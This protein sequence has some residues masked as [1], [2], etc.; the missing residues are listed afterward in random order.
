[1]RGGRSRGARRGAGRSLSAV[2]AAFEASG[3]VYGYRRVRASIASGADGGEPMAVSEREV[4][5]AMREGAHGREAHAAARV[6]VLRGRDRR[7]P[8]ERPRWRADG[9]HDFSAPAPWLTVVT[10]VTEFRVRGG[11]AYLSPVIDCFDGE[12]AAWSVSRHPDSELTDSSLESY[13]ARRP[14]RPEPLVAHS[15]GGST[16]RSG[17]WKRICSEGGVVRSMSRKGCCPDNARAEGFFG[18]LKEEFYNGRDWSQVGFGRVQAD[19]RRLPGMVRPRAT[20]GLP[21]GREDGVRYDS[22]RRRRLGHQV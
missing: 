2:R 1:M 3:R 10:D 13:L 17:S 20:Q 14:G 5:R 16:Y 15:D 12:P 4:R 8:G 22:G 11:K 21:R 19:A 9:T 18:T 7:A 6:V